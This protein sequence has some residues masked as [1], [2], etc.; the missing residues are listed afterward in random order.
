MFPVFSCNLQETLNL[1]PWNEE[2]DWDLYVTRT[3]AKRVPFSSYI[4]LSPSISADSLLEQAGPCFAFGT[5]PAELQLRVL[6]FCPAE[7]LFQLM[8]V[9]TLLRLEASKLFWGDPETYCLVDADWLLEGGYPGYHCLD[10]A[11]LSKM[12]RVEVWYEPSTYNDICYRRDGTT[13]IRQDRIATFWSSLQRLFPHVKSLII[14]QNGEARIWK[15][16]EAVPKPLQLLMQACPLA[17]QL[18]TLVPQRQD[19]T[20]ATDT[21]TWQRSQYRIVSGHI[22]KIDRIYYKTIL[23]PIRRDAGLVSEFERLWSRGIRL[24][25]QQ[26]SLWPLAIEALDRH[27]FDSGKNEPFACLLPGCDTDFKQAGEWSL[28]AARSHYQHTSGFALFPTQ[29][30]ALLEDRKKTIEQ[31]YQEARMRIRNIRYEWQNARQ[32]KRRDIERVWAETLKRNYLWDT[33][34]QVVGNQVWIN[35]VKWANL[36]D[37]SDQV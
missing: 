21:T 22:R 37:E 29:I 4:Q 14:S 6:R 15:S 36:R 3:W 10:L 19:C 16:E 13:E 33:E 11:F 27:H 25:L 34:Q 2:Q 26:Y 23:P 20:I 35:F 1:P 7:T 9:S 17:I 24:Q 5:L 8:H 12:Q 31:S 30:R 18:S 28:H 32:D